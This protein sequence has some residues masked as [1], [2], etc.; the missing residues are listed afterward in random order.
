MKATTR[1][2]FTTPLFF[3]NADPPVL[4]DDVTV[5]K[6]YE[7]VVTSY[8][9]LARYRVGD[10]VKVVG[11]ATIDAAA[12]ADGDAGLE[13]DLHVFNGPP[14]IE[15]VGRAGA[16]LN[17]V[18]EKY[19]E[20]AIVKA[21]GGGDYPWAEFAVRE[22][23]APSGGGL[24]HYV[25]YVEPLAGGELEVGQAVAAAVENALRTQNEIYAMLVARGQIAPAVV[26][27]TRHG[28]FA[29]LKESAVARGASAA[30]YKAPVCLESS[31]DG[32]RS[33]VL[34]EW[35]VERVRAEVV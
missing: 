33:G 30:Q 31:A 21:L 6:N 5:N 10:V 12:L 16:M 2:P 17:L 27:V 1:S 14:I 22:E 24:P 29:A 34:E 9:G 20:A 25:V 19:D 4:F 23:P 32:L 26:A 11:F 15:F 28:A 3:F 7:V 13:A 8:A 18:W 35:V